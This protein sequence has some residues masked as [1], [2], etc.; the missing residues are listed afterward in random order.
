[1]TQSNNFAR[2]EA[3]AG[4][5]T[6]YNPEVKA[7]YLEALSYVERAHRS[8]LDV[9][10]DEFERAGR[11]DVNPVQALILFHMG[12]SELTAGE[13]KTRG[14]Y[15]GSNVSYNLKKL[16]ELGY[17][18]HQRS[19]V[20]RRAVKIKLTDKGQ[21]IRSIVDKLYDRHTASLE[22]VGGISIEDFQMISQ[23]LQ[24]LERFW[25]DQI[26]YRL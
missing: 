16:V 8:L 12:D 18:H 9:I 25:V 24:R 15:L 14:Y 22:V 19:R 2:E 5:V 13:L 4:E 23:T 21:D 11:S 10:K 7:N 20:D 1:M 3:K 26:R 17:V 6:K